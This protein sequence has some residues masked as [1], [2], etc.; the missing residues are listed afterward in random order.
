MRSTLTIR[1]SECPHETIYQTLYLQAKGELRTELKLALR[2]G[3]A[4]RVPRSR[5]ALSRGTIPDMVNMG[6]ERARRKPT[7][8]RCPVSGKEI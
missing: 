8:V 1:R 6:G 5:A 7:I 2:Q 4:R 3:R